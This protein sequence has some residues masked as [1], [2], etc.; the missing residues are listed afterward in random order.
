M[1]E[2]YESDVEEEKVASGE[3]GRE[4]R[5]QVMIRLSEGFLEEIENLSGKVI[6]EIDYRFCTVHRK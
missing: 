3:S 6:I 1:V 2:R 4:S 5:H